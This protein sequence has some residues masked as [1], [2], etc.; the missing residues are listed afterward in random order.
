MTEFERA[1]NENAKEDP[2]N[3]ISDDLETSNFQASYAPGPVIEFC[4]FIL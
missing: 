2:E 4:Q 3:A 1:Y